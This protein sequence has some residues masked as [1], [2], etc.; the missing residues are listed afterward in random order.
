M[1]LSLFPFPFQKRSV[2][3]IEVSNGTFEANYLVASSQLRPGQGLLS[4]G[5]APD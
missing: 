3:H 4:G 1:F 2:D 5:I